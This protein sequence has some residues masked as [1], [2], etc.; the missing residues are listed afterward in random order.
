[1]PGLVV[2]GLDTKIPIDPAASNIH[3]QFYEPLHHWRMEFA[4]CVCPHWCM[5]VA[6]GL[7]FQLPPMLSGT[8]VAPAA[9]AAVCSV[10]AGRLSRRCVACGLRSGV[11]LREFTGDHH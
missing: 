4:A 5:M 6:T 7:D 9:R 1:M 3:G 10:P 8:S 2:V 11:S